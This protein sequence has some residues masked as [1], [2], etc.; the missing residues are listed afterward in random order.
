MTTEKT[1]ACRYARECHETNDRAWMAS[2]IKAFT[3]AP[4]TKAEIARRL[5]TSTDNIEA[6]QKLYFDVEEYVQ[7]RSVLGA[8]LAPLL[9]P[10][11]LTDKREQVWLLAALK[12]GVKGLDY[13]MDRRVNLS[14]F[15]QAQISDA[16]HATLAEQTLA[17]SLSMESRP[18]FGPAA[19]TAY[20][21]SHE[22]R[23]RNPP[24]AEDPASSAWLDG[25]ITLVKEKY[26]ID[27]VED[28]QK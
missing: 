20:H 15:E 26:S 18:E 9:E 27:D 1:V 22:M 17:Y 3:I 7:D 12:L 19:L 11:V 2:R 13:V 5:H 8:I 10:S 21:R 25:L 28:T 24:P 4:L 23:L 6:F 14:P 16:I